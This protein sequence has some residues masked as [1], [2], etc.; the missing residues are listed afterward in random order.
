MPPSFRL[1]DEAELEKQPPSEDLVEG[2]LPCESLG[3]LIASAGLGKT[4]LGLDLAYCV[5][6]GIRWLGRFAVKQGP[7][8]YVAAEGRRGLPIRLRAWK[9]HHRVDRSARVSFL[10]EP[11]Q[12]HQPDDVGALLEALEDLPEN[13]VLIVIDTMARCFV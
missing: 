6:T 4:F 9:Q 7:V 8:V 10:A 5:A 11:V 13:P 3:V 2:V 12:V 1:I